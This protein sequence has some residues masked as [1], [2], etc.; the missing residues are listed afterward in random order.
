MSLVSKL[1]SRLYYITGVSLR[2]LK[3]GSNANSIEY[4][5]KRKV[6]AMMH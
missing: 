5:M 1:C 3:W 2:E 4:E 6:Y